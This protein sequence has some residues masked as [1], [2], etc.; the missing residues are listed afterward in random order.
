M[1]YRVSRG[2]ETLSITDNESQL[3]L[4]GTP[5]TNVGRVRGNNEDSVALWTFDRFMVAL[6]A[7]GMGGAAAGEEASQLAVETVQTKLIELFPDPETWRT[8]SDSEIAEHMRASLHMANQAVLDRAAKDAQ[9]QGMGTTATMAFFRGKQAIFAHIGDSRGY[10]VSPTTSIDQITNDH[11]FVEALV[12][13]GH[14]TPEQAAVHPMKNVLY[15]ALGQKA[16]SEFEVDIYTQ[17]ITPGDRFVLCSDGLPRHVSNK[18]IA[19]IVAFEDEPAD[20]A[21]QLINLANERGGEDNISAVV[22]AIDVIA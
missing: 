15:R 1:E 8:L 16:D 18:E 7:D 17:S 4:K 22:V 12:V 21:E 13:S 19:S 9:L 5:L 11:S 3:I 14:L 10:I 6:V 20:M 2:G